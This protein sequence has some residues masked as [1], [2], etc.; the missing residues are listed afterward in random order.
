MK[1]KNYI[2]HSQGL[3]YDAANAAVEEAIAYYTSLCPLANGNWLAVW[4]C[5]RD[6]HSPDN[7][8]RLGRS[9]DGAKS[10]QRLEVTLNRQ[11]QQ[12]QG[13]FL[14]GEMVEV[15]PGRILLFATW[16]DRSVPERPLFNPETEGILPTR[17]LVCESIDE[18]NHWSDWREVETAQRTG[19]AITG[20]IIQWPDGV[21]GCCF[22]SFK[23]YDDFTK[24]DQM[25]WMVLSDDQGKTFSEPI[26]VA[27]DPKQ[28]QYYW[29]QRICAWGETG[30]LAMFWTHSR[31]QSKDL[32]VHLVKG[33][34]G[35]PN[36]TA[37]SIT[38][39]PGQIAACCAAADNG[40]VA[41]VVNR[42]RPGTMTLWQSD[43][44][45][46]SWPEHARVVVHVHDEQAAITQG[47]TN[48]DFASFWDD[49]GK[50]SFGHPAL[51]PIENGWLVAWYAGSPTR[52]SIHCA[53]VK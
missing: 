5:G 10:W 9:I 22:E 25:T 18:G 32:H 53:H 7:T 16:V 47:L 17:I 35:V 13:S 31:S 23:E 1:P 14:S 3:I 50:W 12:V 37:P 46:S 29:D 8:L 27:T 48:I 28:E 21:I 51:R 15:S 24:V 45:G 52:M 40:I 4:Q 11:F 41:F 39:I 43:D 44:G 6:K 33:Q 26:L 2:I 20:P 30:Y 34:R 19:C 36:R 42:D 38:C 49:M